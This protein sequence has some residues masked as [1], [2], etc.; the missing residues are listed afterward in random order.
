MCEYLEYTG[1]KTAII[2]LDPANEANS[3][4]RK[5]WAVD[6]SRL[7]TVADAMNDLELGPNGSLIFCMEYLEK[8]IDWLIKELKKISGIVLYNFI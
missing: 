1:R 8:N 3:N 5:Q 6:I 4:T 2:N 7:I